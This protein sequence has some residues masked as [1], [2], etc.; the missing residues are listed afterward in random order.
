MSGSV[1]PIDRKYP[2]R[3]ETPVQDWGS[4]GIW[5]ARPKGLE[6]LTF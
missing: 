1:G 3:D 6:P 4:G 2:E 5:P